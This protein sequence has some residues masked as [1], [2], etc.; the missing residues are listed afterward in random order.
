MAQLNFLNLLVAAT[1]AV[2]ALS[3]SSVPV[4]ALSPDSH[5]QIFARRGVHHGM[6]R[7]PA[8]KKKRSN[9][10]RCKVRESSSAVSSST[11]FS[12]TPTS[13]SSATPYVAPTS[14]S[15]SSSYVASSTSSASTP[16][17]SGVWT[18]P[19]G[20]LAWPNGDTGKLANWKTNHMTYLYTWGSDPL[21]EAS[22][23]GFQVLPQLWGDKDTA[24][25]S[26]NIGSYTTPTYVL[27]FNEP[28]EAGQSNMT[29]DHAVQL[30]WQ[31]IEPQKANG[32]KLVAPAVSSSPAG[33]TWTQEFFSKCVGCTI[34]AIATHYYDV[35]ASDFIAYQNKFHDTFGLP[36]LVTEY[37]CQNFNNGPQCTSDEIWSFMTTTTA[38]MDS[39][40]WIISYMWFG[41]MLDMYNVNYQCQLM[42]SDGTPNS[43]G[44][45]F[46]NGY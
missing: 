26:K 8:S 24:T 31:Y 41:A 7:E 39:T 45:K 38:W 37:A 36:I 16:S 20:G 5:G 6:R 46:I 18:G 21:P 11:V 32:H 19:K 9:S 12:Y 30:W 1:L 44:Y 40:D 35:S 22:N 29:P 34:D 25:F 2:I 4:A 23:V 27:A 15:S 33:F 13:T 10:K 3:Y 28:N 42:G 14:S 17:S 43:L